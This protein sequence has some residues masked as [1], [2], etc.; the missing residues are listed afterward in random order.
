MG[1]LKDEDDF[2]IWGRS[3]FLQ[4]EEKMVFSKLSNTQ[5][6]L[7]LTKGTWKLSQMVGDLPQLRFEKVGKK[8]VVTGSSKTDEQK[9]ECTAD[10]VCESILDT[11]SEPGV[12]AP[13][14]AN[15]ATSTT[16]KIL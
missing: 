8:L 2:E 13:G 9:V 15:R 14:P 4:A 7:V 11:T 10:G 1:D 5:S 3:C 6:S 16:P 12:M